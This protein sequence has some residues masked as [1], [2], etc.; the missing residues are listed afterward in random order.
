MR[1]RKRLSFD[2][3]AGHGHLDT[4]TSL[5]SAARLVVCASLPLGFFG[6]AHFAADAI[7]QFPIFFAPFGMPHWGGAVLHLAQLALLG[8]AFWAL[9]E[10]ATRGTARQWLIGLT[11]LYILLPFVTPLLDSQQL[12]LICTAL[13]LGTLATIRRVGR[14]APVAGWLMAPMLAIT[15]TSAALGL[16]MAAAYSPPFALMQSGHTQPAAG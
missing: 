1:C 16:T 4:G 2:V 14:A 12:G 9:T 3:G 5:Q 15:G 7:G 10:Q 8:A 11:A 6:L 13:F